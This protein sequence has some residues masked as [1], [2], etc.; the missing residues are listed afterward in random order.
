MQRAL[1][2]IITVFLILQLSSCKITI[3]K[4]M[5]LGGDVNDIV[6]I[7]VYEVEREEYIGSEI[8]DSVLDIPG[9]C[10]PIYTLTGD[11]IKLF[12]DELLALEYAR[13][14]IVP[15]PVDYAH[16][17]APGYVVFI[18]YACMGC[19]VYAEMGIY[20]HRH[21]DTGISH[22]YSHDDCRGEV[23]FTELIE[24]YLTD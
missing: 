3:E 1:T 11:E 16:L 7:S 8:G 18:E 2:L 13:D 4:E 24:K 21:H 6:A 5:E 23:S 15:F 20:T 22:S 9:E 19:D 17:F 10:E 12:V 14:E